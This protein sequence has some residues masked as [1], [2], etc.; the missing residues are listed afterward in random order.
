MLG[1]H[2]G[3]SEPNAPTLVPASQGCCGGTGNC[4]REAPV[5][6]KGLRQFRRSGT[7]DRSG[8]TNLITK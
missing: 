5:R 1:D 8:S 6:C 4:H 2:L 3:P 7:Q